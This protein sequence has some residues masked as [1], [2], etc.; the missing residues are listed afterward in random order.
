M[1]VVTC[2]D[3]NIRLLSLISKLVVIKDFECVFNA[4]TLIQVL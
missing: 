4:V 3:L 2:N 1:R